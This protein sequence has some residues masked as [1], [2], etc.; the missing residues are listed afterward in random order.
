MQSIQLGLQPGEYQ[1]LP[2]STIWG[3][4]IADTGVSA[5]E[6]RRDCKSGLKLKIINIEDHGVYSRMSLKLDK[7]IGIQYLTI[8][9][10]CAADEA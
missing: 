6:F 1:K 2:A 4:G 5:E 8:Q 10:H 3:K 7:S 9:L